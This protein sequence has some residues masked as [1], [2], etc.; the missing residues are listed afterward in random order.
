MNTA[1][2]KSFLTILTSKV[3]VERERLYQ[4]V[5]TA[6]VYYR[7]KDGQGQHKIGTLLQVCDYPFNIIGEYY[8]A[9]YLN[10]IGRV[11]EAKRNLERIIENGTPEYRAKAILTLSGVEEMQGNFEESMRLR[12]KA[13]CVDN[14]PVVVEAQLGIAAI[15]GVSGDHLQAVKQLEKFLPMARLVG[16][17][18][19]YIYGFSQQLCSRAG[20]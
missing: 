2:A 14:Y 6:E 11:S 10:Q 20:R 5:R 8:D 18:N 12:L 7:L 16:G 3:G 17:G 4:L 9:F 15:M 13:S 1:T 19:P